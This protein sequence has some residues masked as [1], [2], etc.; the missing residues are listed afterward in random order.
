MLWNRILCLI[1]FVLQRLLELLSI[2]PEDW[3]RLDTKSKVLLGLTI[4]VAVNAL[5]ALFLPG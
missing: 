4:S 2:T 1:N 3:S 5:G